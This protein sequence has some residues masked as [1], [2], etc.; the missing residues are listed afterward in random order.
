LP[1]WE[2]VVSVA[3]ILELA[4]VSNRRVLI[5]WRERERRPFPKPSRTLKCGELWDRRAVERWLAESR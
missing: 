4:G 2:D 3:E 5:Q 1:K